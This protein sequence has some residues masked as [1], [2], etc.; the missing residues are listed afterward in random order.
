MNLAVLV[1]LI[2]VNFAV[3]VFS[4]YVINAAHAGT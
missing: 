4:V 1:V 2:T 3:A